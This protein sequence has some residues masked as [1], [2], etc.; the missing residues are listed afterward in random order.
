MY[1]AD[2][3]H[4]A[5][6]ILDK[7]KFGVVLDGA[8]GVLPEY[9]FVDSLVVSPEG[10][11]VAYVAGLECTVSEKRGYAVLSGTQATGSRWWVVHGQEKSREYT[12]VREPTWSPDGK[13]IAFAGCTRGEWRVFV[14][15]D[16]SPPC[17]EV[18][19]LVWSSDSQSVSFASRTGMDIAWTTLKVE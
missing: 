18:A 9:D 11:Q 10:D 3:K 5:F 1:S 17:S 6:K 12:A 15:K 7:D 16:S 14:G 4:V 2:G 13:R 8:S 19:G